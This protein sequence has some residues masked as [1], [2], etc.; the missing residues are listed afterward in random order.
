[1]WSKIVV[2]R[3]LEFKVSLQYRPDKEALHAG[4]RA[5]TR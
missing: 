5:R 3:A 1:M 2:S 4:C